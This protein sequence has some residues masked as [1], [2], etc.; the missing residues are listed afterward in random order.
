MRP[1]ALLF[2][3]G[4]SQIVIPLYDEE[5][6]KARHPRLRIVTADRYVPDEY[7][8]PALT[9]T[10]EDRILAAGDSLRFRL[11]ENYEEVQIAPDGK[12]DFPQVGRVICTGKKLSE[13]RQILAEKFRSIELQVS[14][15]GPDVVIVGMVNFEGPLR[16]R[17]ESLRQALAFANGLSQRANLAQILVIRGE[18]IIVCDYYHYAAEGDEKQNLAIRPG[19]LIVVTELYDPDVV[20]C[21][22]EW[23]VLDRHMSDRKALFDALNR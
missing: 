15:R 12:V 16:T 6:V 7:K 11:E 2:L 23:A 14:E 8:P 22:P 4:C 10:T 17:T 1:L 13:L 5:P 3:A 21:A 9:W 18:Q 19:D 20:P